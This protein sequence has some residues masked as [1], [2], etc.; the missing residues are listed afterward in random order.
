MAAGGTP[1]NVNLGPGRLYYAPLGTAEP[2]T[3]SAALPSAWQAIGYTEDG[4][5]ISIDISAEDIMVA[6]ELD[7]VDRVVTSRT[8]RLTTTLAESTRKR[9]QLAVGGG[10]GG[11]DDSTPYELPDAGAEV[12]VML[13]WDSDETPSATNRRWLFRSAQAA[14]TITTVRRKAPAKNSIQATFTASKPTGSA[15]PI[16]IFPNASGQ[17]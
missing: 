11:V 3:C 8:I 10:A 12:A 5:E 1:A 7:P 4:T 13:V 6:E 16:R 2:T 14:G 15:G 17:V 9:L